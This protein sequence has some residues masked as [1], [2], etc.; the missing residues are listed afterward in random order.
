MK[1]VDGDNCILG[2]LATF[3]AKQALNGEEVKVYNAEKIVI[4]G[5]PVSIIDRA[6]ER[7]E[8]RNIA[9]PEL[10]PHFSRRPDLYVKRVVRGMLPRKTQRGAAAFRRVRIY[11]GVPNELSG[12]GEKIAEA[13]NVRVKT[14]TVGEVCKHLGWNA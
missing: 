7:F 5:N 12:K 6:K 1:I 13:K 11:L 9:S 14:V 8:I 2:R 3:V 10:S 4:T